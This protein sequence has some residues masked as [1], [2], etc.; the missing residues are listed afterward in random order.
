VTAKRTTMVASTCLA[1]ALVATACGGSGDDGGGSG[2]DSNSVEVFSWWTSGSESDALQVLF[3]K[4]AAHADG[5]VVNA[6][7]SG[8]GGSNARQA[9]AT[10]LQGGDPPDSWQLHPDKDLMA[11][12]ADGT[13]ADI[14]NLYEDNG[15]VDVIP[16][17]VLDMLGSEGKYYAVPVNAHRGNV[18]WTNPAVLS[19]NGITWDASTT[20]EQFMSDAQKLSDSGVTPLC[21]GDKDIFAA[22]QLLETL[23]MGQIGADGW[24]QL[25]A[26]DLAFDDAGVKTA[27]ENYVTLL[28]QANEDH[29]ALTW[30]QAAINMANGD[31]ASNLM[32]DWAYGELKNKGFEEGNGFGYAVMPGTSDIFDF[33]GDAFV[34]P[35]DNAPNAEGEDIWLAGLLDPKVQADFNLLKGSTPIRTDVPLDDFPPYQQ[36]AANDFRSVSIVSS[37]AH[38]EAAPSEFCQAFA[39]AVT[40]LNGDEN[41]DNFLQAMVD[42]QTNL[43][44]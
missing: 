28:G 36:A 21:L 23:I 43:L 17:A 20:S 14:T 31:C 15:W 42:A 5:E 22:T 10:R 40:S 3:D 41:V 16:Q 34:K 39:D 29:S 37:L 12:V 13:V 18:L 35:A 9:L 7:V 8:G 4:Y 1:L 25:V 19:D 32:G 11:A 2:G 24:T 6:A 44:G 27:V 30:D 38:F 26:G 33:V